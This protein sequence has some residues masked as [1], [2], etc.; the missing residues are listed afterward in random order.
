M[1]DIVE[2]F[3]K[4]LENFQAA[5]EAFLKKEISV[6]QYKGIS[7]KY[8]SYAQ[9]GGESSMLRL[10]M[11]GGRVTKDKLAFIVAA[12]EREGIDKIH[13]T[14]CQ[15]VQL[16]DVK[17]Q[18]VSRLILE[19]LDCGIV[20]WGGGGDFPRNVMVSPL[21]GVEAGEYFDVMPYAEKVA[22]YLLGFI[23][24]VKLPRKLKV[25]FS[26]SP[27][28]ETHATFRDLGFVARS[29]GHFDVYSAGGLGSNPKMGVLVAK[30]VAPHKILYYVKA[31]IETFMTYGDYENRG[32]ARTRY[33]QDRLGTEGYRAAYLETLSV[34]L[35]SG[36][37]LDLDVVPQPVLENGN[38]S[39]FETNQNRIVPQK[40]HGLYAVYY[41]PIGGTPEIETIKRIYRL[42]ESMDQGELRLTP[43]QGMYLI[44]CNEEVAKQFVEMTK[45]GANNS[46]ETSVACIGAAVCQV[47]VRDSQ[48]L[49]KG[50]IQEMKGCGFDQET[51]PVIHISG[52]PSS[53]GTHQIGQ[54]GF[55]GGVKLINQ[56]A[57]PAY[58]LHVNGKDRLGCEQFGTN[59]GV[60]LEEDIFPF[61]REVGNRVQSSQ[62]SY[63]AW[64]EGD[65][66]GL[67]KIARKYLK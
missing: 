21:S 1:K 40:Q 31:M 23:D 20:T 24:S 35:D 36:E 6:A 29:D 58:T 65:T 37:N 60:I 44:N 25:G 30:Q 3:K 45:D 9:R 51:L 16:H 34:V 17:P 39:I 49:L 4:D 26:N 62:L 52:C 50:L 15:T 42:M 64:A 7:G 28:N 41:H 53:C 61:L 66:E 48:K 46:F 8:G 18:S 54:I 14:T 19:A 22:N 47:G 43:N 67:E 57:H 38:G 13:L 63:S 32:K 5:T 27:R 33:M 59:L 2:E 10:R 56:V 11:N 12:T 55:H